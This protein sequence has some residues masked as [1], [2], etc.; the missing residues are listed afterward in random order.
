MH[1]TLFFSKQNKIYSAQYPPDMEKN[2][3]FQVRYQKMAN[4]LLKKINKK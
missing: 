4:S 3:T 1:A 2:K